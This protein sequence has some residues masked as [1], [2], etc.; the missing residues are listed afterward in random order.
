MYFAKYSAFKLH[1]TPKNVWFVHVHFI[2]MG[3][4]QK[5]TY[6]LSKYIWEFA[7]KEINHCHSISIF[8]CRKNGLKQRCKWYFNRISDIFLIES[9]FF[10]FKMPLIVFNV[11][12]VWTVLLLVDLS[13][14]L[15]SH[16]IHIGFPSTWKVEDHLCNTLKILSYFTHWHRAHLHSAFDI[17][18][19]HLHIQL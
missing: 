2:T 12:M 18:E 4:L 1:P 3:S 17:N 9:Y 13:Q 6:R 14:I 7:P 10:L 8:R 15:N 19:N 11:C 16:F 5:V